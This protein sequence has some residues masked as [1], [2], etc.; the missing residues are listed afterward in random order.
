MIPEVQPEPLPTSFRRAWLYN[1]E[2][3]CL[4]GIESRSS[5]FASSSTASS[6][7]AGRCAMCTDGHRGSSEED[8]DMPAMP[9]KNRRPEKRARCCCYYGHHYYDDD[10]IQRYYS[11]A[12]VAAPPRDGFQCL[13][14]DHSSQR[15]N[16][17]R[18]RGV[19][20]EQ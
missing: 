4:N 9:S 2:S 13:S 6:M 3:G 5:T 8:E 12:A 7:T 15:I 18:A 1:N 20:A 11:P 14:F 19:E 16:F 17:P 10:S